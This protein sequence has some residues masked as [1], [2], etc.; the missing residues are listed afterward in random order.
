MLRFRLIALPE[1]FG[2]LVALQ[3]LELGRNQLTTLP[4]SFGDLIA[5]QV[6]GEPADDLTLPESFCQ[7]IEAFPPGSGS[8]KSGF[9]W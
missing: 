5:L 9:E 7:F 6:L 1:S 2:Q 3:V 8:G 4:A